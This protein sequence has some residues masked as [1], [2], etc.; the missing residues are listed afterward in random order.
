MPMF[1]RIVGL[2]ALFVASWLVLK[3]FFGVVA[4]LVGLVVSVLALAAVGYVCYVLLSAVS[5]RMAGKVR[6]AI[7]GHPS[8]VL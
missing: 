4:T 2:T 8:T 6:G 1:R 3:V 7:M 5:P